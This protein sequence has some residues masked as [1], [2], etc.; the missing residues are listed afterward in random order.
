MSHAR[1]KRSLDRHPTQ[2]MAWL[3]ARLARYITKRARAPMT[4][5]R[6]QFLTW[7]AESAAPVMWQEGAEWKG[8]VAGGRRRRGEWQCGPV[9]AAYNA[10]WKRGHEADSL[11]ISTHTQ[12]SA[13]TLRYYVYDCTHENKR[14][15][16][17]GRV[18]EQCA[19]PVALFRLQA[20][21]SVRRR[22]TDAERGTGGVHNATAAIPPC[23]FLL[24]CQPNHSNNLGPRGRSTHTVHTWRACQTYKCTLHISHS[25]ACFNNSMSTLACVP[26]LSGRPEDGSSTLHHHYCWHTAPPLPTL[27]SVV[28][29]CTY[30]LCP[31]S[32]NGRWE[33][34]SKAGQ[35]W[36][37]AARVWVCSLVAA[38]G[39]S[40]AAVRGCWQQLVLCCLLPTVC[41]TAQLVTAWVS[42]VCGPASVA[43]GSGCS[44]GVKVSEAPFVSGGMCQRSGAN[45][46]FSK[47][48]TGPLGGTR[49]SAR[50][51]PQADGGQFTHLQTC[52]LSSA[53]A[54]RS[55]R[56]TLGSVAPLPLY[57][58]NANEVRE[59]VANKSVV[60]KMALPSALGGGWAAAGL[61]AAAAPVGGQA[62]YRLGAGVRVQRESCH[63]ISTGSRAHGAETGLCLHGK[64][65]VCVLVLR[66]AHL[67]CPVPAF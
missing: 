27:L 67:L 28:R 36:V 63:S 19:G 3:Y 54:H 58:M 25:M 33:L 53:I 8:V 56:H 23:P 24:Q 10:D 1:P 44:G 22:H 32:C 51:R 55:T 13:N 31:V 2:Y 26:A 17:D 40:A 16:R 34:I 52:R 39:L 59:R 65:G 4:A 50:R 60:E 46:N 6:S 35:V 12:R 21:Q 41:Q 47:K 64:C 9:S 66:D 45:K 62:A 30:L 38:V 15:G 7:K 61:S 20:P 42:G 18:S 48:R 57:K 43:V 29:A 5:G 49:G 11:D 14:C 37:C